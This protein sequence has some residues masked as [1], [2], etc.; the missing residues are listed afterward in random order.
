MYIHFQNFENQEIFQNEGKIYILPF[1][2]LYKLGKLYVDEMNPILT[3]TILHA[4]CGQTSNKP[5][6]TTAVLVR[7]G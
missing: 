5:D 7:G 2:L 4:H 1:F 3:K 6:K